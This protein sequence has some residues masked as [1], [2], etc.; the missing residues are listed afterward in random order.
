MGKTQGRHRHRLSR[1]HA[2]QAKENG[3]S[4]TERE[5]DANKNSE[6]SAFEVH[7]MPFAAHVTC[8]KLARQ[9]SKFPNTAKSPNAASTEAPVA[10]CHRGGGRRAE[11]MVHAQGQSVENIV[12]AGMLKRSAPD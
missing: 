11:W 6:R 12:H 4:H 3:Q 10:T 8:T 5:S 9:H 1:R 2:G 7:A